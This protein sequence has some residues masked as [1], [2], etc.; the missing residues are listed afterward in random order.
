LRARANEHPRNCSKSVFSAYTYQQEYIQRMIRYRKI[1]EYILILRCRK[2]TSLVRATFVSCTRA[3]HDAPR[4]RG[5]HNICVIS[6]RF[7]PDAHVTSANQ[8][9][10]LRALA[11]RGARYRGCYFW[12]P[13]VHDKG[14]TTRWMR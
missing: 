4:T 6:A 9:Q 8:T 2:V 12:T 3:M 14:Y 1:N 13:T 5:L 7:T 10:M 11:A